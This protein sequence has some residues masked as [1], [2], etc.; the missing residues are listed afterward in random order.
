MV[1]TVGH[2]HIDVAW[3]WTLAQTEEKAQR[4]FSTVLRLMEQYPEFIFMSS[5][6]QLYEYIKKN[7]PDLYRQI[8]ER[9]RQGRWEVEGAMWLEA[10][11][12]LTSGES[13]VRQV[14]HGKRFMQQEFGV[15]SHILWLPDVFGYSAALP[16]ILRKAGVDRFFTTKIG[17]NE[18]NKMPFDAFMWEGIDGTEIFT[19]FGTARNLPKPGG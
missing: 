11:C 18:T 4:S 16:Q 13:L 15:D 10:D 2:T 6:P 17:W 12:N 5:Q 9:V 19:H 3:L 8:Q 1:H 14:L 7:A